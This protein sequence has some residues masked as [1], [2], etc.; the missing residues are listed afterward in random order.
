ME[1]G[2]S[3]MDS[4]RRQGPRWLA[5]LSLF[6]VAIALRSLSFPFVFVGDRVRVPGGYD[7][8]YHLRRIWF[9]VVNFPAGLAF[10][11]YLDH[12][13]GARPPWTPL[14]DWGIG[15]LA[16]LLAGAGSQSAVEA[17]AV[18]VPPVLGALTIVAVALLARRCFGPAAGWLSG[19][20]LAVLPVHIGYSE[21]SAVD[22]HVAVVLLALLLVAPRCGS[23]SRSTPGVGGA[24]SWRPGR[25]PRC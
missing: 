19:L 25:W 16:R 9:T 23:P 18:W 6:G 5:W 24:A 4:T 17:V 10:D 7:E 2:P 11:R 13:R 20:L 3:T 14:F 8:F 1:A 12:P 22:H 15:A 21:L